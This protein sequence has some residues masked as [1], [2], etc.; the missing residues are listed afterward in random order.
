MRVIQGTS[1]VA[2]AW[3]GRPLDSG[4]QS[5][6]GWG[7]IQQPRLILPPG[8]SLCVT[9]VDGGLCATYQTAPLEKEPSLLNV[10]FHRSGTLH[11]RALCP[12]AGRNKLAGGLH[13]VGAKHGVNES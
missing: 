8:A 5:E 2:S 7:K 12:P 13:A 9:A 10:C 4:P 11:D 3:P 6:G 1:G